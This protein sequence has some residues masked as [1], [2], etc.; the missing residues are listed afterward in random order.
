MPMVNPF[1]EVDWN[2]SPAALRAFAKS[3]VVGFPCLGL[4]LLII[5][6]ISSGQWEAQVPLLVAGCGVF[7]A[8]VFWLIPRIAKPFYIVWYCLACSIGLLLGNALLALVFYI[9]VTLIGL[10]M[11]LLGRDPLNRKLDKNAKTYWLDVE[12]DD[13]PQRYYRQF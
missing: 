7:A 1:K 5:G 2:P 3:L 10:G 11:R 9:V 8:I 13:D 12:R 6:R 4:A